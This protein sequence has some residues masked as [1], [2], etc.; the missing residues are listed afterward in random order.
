MGPIRKGLGSEVSKSATPV[1]IMEHLPHLQRDQVCVF[2]NVMNKEFDK[3][4]HFVKPLWL[5]LLAVSVSFFKF[6][7]QNVPNDLIISIKESPR[8]WY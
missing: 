3:Q 5:G 2:Q 8:K 6:I 1:T 4:R 7:F